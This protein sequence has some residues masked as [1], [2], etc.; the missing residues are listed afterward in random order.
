[1]S[2]VVFA[3]FPFIEGVIVMGEGIR[4]NLMPKNIQIIIS[5]E[6]FETQ[7]ENFELERIVMIELEKLESFLANN[8]S[9]IAGIPT[10]FSIDGVS[11][12]K[13]FSKIDPYLAFVKGK[14]AREIYQFANIAGIKI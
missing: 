6:L 12:T 13:N 11:A 3:K 8:Y 14:H 7:Q 2:K 5:A 9:K 10:K 4:G 1:M